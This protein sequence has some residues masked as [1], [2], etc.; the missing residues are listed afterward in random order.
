MSAFAVVNPRSANGRTAREWRAIA[1]LLSEIYPRLDVAFTRAPR[2][3]AH[4]V[5]TA[6][7]EGHHEIV[8][9]G[10]DGTI[11]EAVNGFFDIN[12]PVSPDAVFSFITSGTGGD[13]RKSFGVEEGSGAALAH[14]KS[15]PIRSVD[16]GRL[17][18]LSRKGEPL[19]RHFV[20]IASFGLSGAVVDSVNRSRIAKLFG[21]PFAF[22][23]HS[24]LDMLTYSDRVVRLIVDNGYDE[25]AAI[26]TV[27]VANG[28]YFGGG[29]RVAPSAAVDDG[30]F[31]VVVMTGG[32]RARMLQDMKLIYS[33]EHIDSPNVRVLRGRKV[34]AVPVAQ[35]RGLAVLIETDGESAGRLPATFEILPRALQLRC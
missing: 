9:V 29:M 7:R 33:G 18:C 30:A 31:D 1:P 19:I 11:N 6:L 26:S 16:V 15:A 32:S 35:T 17:S 12:G 27:A 20:N 23:F 34:V 3:A 8:A 28:Q 24:A 14:L 5:R 4:L 22:G 13:F 2:D 10:G 25:I 21:G